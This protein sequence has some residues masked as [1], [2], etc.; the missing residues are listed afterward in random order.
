MLSGT[1]TSA[2]YFSVILLVLG[3]LFSAPSFAERPENLD[4]MGGYFDNGH[5]KCYAEPCISIHKNT[6]PAANDN[7]FD[8]RAWPPWLDIDQDC[9]LEHHQALARASL[10]PVRYVNEDQCLDVIAG[11]WRDPYSARI[12]KKSEDM[13]V[14]H[15]VSLQE[16]HYFGGAAWTRD[17]RV[18]FVNAQ[19]NLVAVSK[20]QKEARRGRPAYKWMPPNKRY[21][22]DYIVHRE[23]VARK[24]DLN[25]PSK[26]RA[27][28]KRIKNLYCKY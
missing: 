19:E 26:E 23:K 17:Q 18:L 16:A 9:Q 4:F 27:Y 11:Q 22:C 8:P 21:W 14:D 6:Y 28:N 25:F 20:E 13:A 7:P 2:R 5:Y 24:F 3:A 1:V 12:L 15:R 10:E